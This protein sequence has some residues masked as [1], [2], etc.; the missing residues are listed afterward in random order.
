MCMAFSLS[1]QDI[2][3]FEIEWDGLESVRAS[4]NL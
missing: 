3:D 1:A 2:F 4:N